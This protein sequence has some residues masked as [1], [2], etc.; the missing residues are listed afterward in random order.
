MLRRTAVLHATGRFI[1]AVRI[2]RAPLLVA[3]I[4]AVGLAVPEQSREILRVLALDFNKQLVQVWSGFLFLALAALAIWRTASNL[5]ETHVAPEEAVSLGVLSRLPLICGM[6]LPVGMAGALF[7]SSREL[8]R[9]QLPN[10]VLSALTGG[11]PVPEL[12]DVAAAPQRLVAGVAVALGIALLVAVVAVLWRPRIGR[13][14]AQL[15]DWDVLGR[16]TRRAMLVLLASLI[17]YYAAFPVDV[18]QALGTV[19]IFLQFVLF[20]AFCASLL[21]L[22]A[23][24]YRV[25]AI[26]ILFVWA[27]LLSA[28]DFNDNHTIRP[29]A[30]KADAPA[31]LRE[32]FS[33]WYESRV[34]RLEY[35]QTG[36]PYPV[37][38]VAAAGGGMYAAQHA[39][40]VLARLQD[41]CPNFAQHVFAISGVS[42]GSLGAAVFATL[43]KRSAPN[44]PRQPC[45]L[46]RSTA[47]GDMERRANQ[48]LARDYLSP[49]VASGL[50]PD[51]LQRF[52]PI[53]IEQF[54][55]GRAFEA[56]LEA[57]WEQALPGED[58][59][60]KK[61]F[62]EHW[63]PA[64]EKR[65]IPALVLN[66]TSVFYGYRVPIRPFR[67]EIFADEWARLTGVIDFQSY[68]NQHMGDSFDITLGAA[69]GLS[70][71]FPWVMPAGSVEVV[72][73]Q[74]RLKPDG[75]GFWDRWLGKRTYR[76]LVDGGYYENSGMESV[77]DIIEGLRDLLDPD[78]AE[79]MRRWGPWQSVPATKR[80]SL[81]VIAINSFQDREEVGQGV[82]ELLSPVRTMLNTRQ[83]RGYLALDRSMKELL[84]LE[85]RTWSPFVLNQT[86][87]AFPLGWQISD[88]MRRLIS[89]HT[90]EP[91]G[92]EFPGGW[93][94]Y[95]GNLIRQ[96]RGRV[97]RIE[98]F[99][100]FG[101]LGSCQIV[102]ALH[103]GD[104]STLKC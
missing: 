84:L 6:L 48:V 62:L 89:A 58:N 14:P 16:N 36:E 26:S 98:A 79:R 37:I 53:P 101:H 11:D 78:H 31:G 51:F 72:T 54:D 61:G 65:A 35:E 86:D 97:G 10:E 91:T 25:P 29:F 83:K 67:S 80:F 39:A 32:A 50:F 30:A 20:L 99:L 38:L 60:F 15:G 57:A 46:S 75:D 100:N 64:D 12:T 19:S 13:E 70:A 56:A 4:G 73:T 76:R 23:D 47:P 7:W 92:V 96:D 66:T 43:A 40:T 9:Q 44:G 85:G 77:L 74:R 22:V 41:R 90:G 104:A 27:V 49:V 2:V 52:L 88:V 55:R 8:G 34:D 103:V 17:L 1:G 18:P 33:Q 94:E 71:R 28:L 21:T 24:K 87:F 45:N 102:R 63:A 59:P 69:V 68:I 95:F 82:S 93:L 3:L 81:H 42:G 5:V